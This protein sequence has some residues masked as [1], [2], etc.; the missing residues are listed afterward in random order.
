MDTDLKRL[1]LIRIRDLPAQDPFRCLA[2]VGTQ[3]GQQQ[4]DALVSAEQIDL[5]IKRD[6][7]ESAGAQKAGELL[8]GMAEKHAFV[9]LAE[10]GEAQPQ[11]LSAADGRHLGDSGAQEAEQRPGISAAAGL[12][13]FQI[14]HAVHA[15]QLRRIGAELDFQHCRTFGWMASVIVPQRTAEGRDLFP[16][17]GQARRQRVAAEALQILSAGAQRL[18]EVESPAAAAGAF[19]AV[20]VQAD[21][22]GR[23]IVRLSQP[24]RGDADDALVPALCCQDDRPVRNR[25]PQQFQRLP[26]D[27]RLQ[28]L[29]VAVELAQLCGQFGGLLWGVC[30]KQ[31]RCALH[32]AQPPGGVQPGCEGKPDVCGADLF[33]SETGF[34][35]QGFQSGAGIALQLFNAF[36]DDIAVFPH[37]GHHVRDGADGDQVRVAVQ[38]PSGVALHRAEQLEG[39]ADACQIVARIGAVGALGVH[40]CNGGGQRFPALVVV[41]DDHVDAEAV[42]IGSFLHGRYTAVDGDDQADPHPVQRIHGGGVDAVAFLHA[43]GD[44]ELTRDAAPAQIICHHAGAGDP[45]HVIIAVD[46][47]MFSVRDGALQTR[48]RRREIRQQQGIAQQGLAAVQKPP[49]LLR[50]IHAALMQHC[51][52]KRSAAGAEQLLRN[53]RGSGRDIPLRI[54]HHT[55]LISAPDIRR[56]PV[57]DG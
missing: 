5:G 24:G 28:C 56:R 12:Q 52:K 17:N 51:R 55:I 30:Q 31:R 25:V 57:T 54:T 8:D 47:D 53:R 39:H 10:F 9:A 16:V 34:L 36:F 27:V 11:M 2:F 32:L 13:A 45:V 4:L 22:D 23:D 18:K 3:T 44:V 33:F 19:S 46:R 7:R 29:A 37:Q 48:H 41:G 40:D 50:C 20:S 21:H 38:Y 43:V 35:N 6:V 26:P 15:E 14:L 49:S 42:G 1:V